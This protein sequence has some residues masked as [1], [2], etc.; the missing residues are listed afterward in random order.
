[1]SPAMTNMSCPDDGLSAFPP[2]RPPLF[3][4]AYRMLRS[5][6]EAEHVVQDVWLRWQTI[7]RSVLGAPEAFLATTATRL[8][9]HVMRWARARGETFIGR[10][11][12]GPGGTSSDPRAG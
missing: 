5:A 8:A 9:I 10:R 2:V 4:I 11:E 12:A 7:G 6:D 3:S 1:M